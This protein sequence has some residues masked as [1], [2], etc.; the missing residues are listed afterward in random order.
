MARKHPLSRR[1]FLTASGAI[2]TATTATTVPATLAHATE[3]DPDTELLALVE[4]WKEA[5]EHHRQAAEALDRAE[6]R[7]Y[8]T[9]PGFPDAC[10]RQPGDP[11]LNLCASLHV[12]KPYD[13]SDIEE[14]RKHGRKRTLHE[15]L[16]PEERARLGLPADAEKIAR[17]EPWPEAQ[18]RSDG[19]ISAWD[20]YHADLERAREESGVDAAEEAETEA[21]NAVDDI[22]DEIARTRAHS[23]K[24]MLIKA[25][26]ASIDRMNRSGLGHDLESVISSHSSTPEVIGLSLILDILHMNGGQA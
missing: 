13:R 16:T 22:R 5:W 7:Y 6:T 15:I 2:L 17:N 10:N 25:Q 23:L 24:G 19:I 14:L 20:K 1:G 8:A 18:A 9:R 21:L 3:P 4:E 26:L 12:G 11:A